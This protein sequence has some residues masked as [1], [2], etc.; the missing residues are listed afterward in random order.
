MTA[1]MWIVRILVILLLIRMVLRMLFPRGLQAPRGRRGPVER[2]G[3]TLVRD[4]QCGTYLPQSRA[5]TVGSGAS[6]L[7]FCSAECREAYTAA[8]RRRA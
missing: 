1:L 3:G 6:T 7:Y 4:P 5:L 2:S 8:E